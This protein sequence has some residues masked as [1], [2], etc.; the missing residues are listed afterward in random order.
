MGTLPPCAQAEIEQQQIERTSR[1]VCR[2]Q[3][4]AISLNRHDSFCRRMA[5]D[6]RLLT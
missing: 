5:L 2:C 3:Q 4:A 1:Q 6:G